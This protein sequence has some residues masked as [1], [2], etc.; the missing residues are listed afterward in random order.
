MN[1]ILSIKPT[2]AH[3]I[4]TG[5]KKVEF[6]K[7]PFKQEVERV[8][9]YS[10]APDMRLVGYFTVKDTVTANP[11]ALWALFAHVGGIDEADFFEY[12]SG[13]EKGVT[14]CIDQVVKFSEG[15][16]PR[17]IIPNFVPPQSFR[18]I[19]L[20]IEESWVSR[21]ETIPA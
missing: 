18:Y 14:F 6:R 17:M 15:I 20:D 2:Y 10:S 3:Q 19:A 16:D 8:Y 13:K 21:L 7:A 9:I 12:Y 1:A 11:S 4:L 5:E